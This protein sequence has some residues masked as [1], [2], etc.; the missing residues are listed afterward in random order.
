MSSKLVSIFY[1]KVVEPKVKLTPKLKIT[2]KMK[3]SNMNYIDVLTQ[4]RSKKKDFKDTNLYTNLL[5]K[6]NQ[7]QN[8]LRYKLFNK[9]S[10][11]QT[12]LITEPNR[13]NNQLSKY[14][15]ISNNFTVADSYTKTRSINSKY[16][17]T[18]KR[19]INKI[20]KFEEEKKQIK[21]IKLIKKREPMEL[22]NNYKD[23][24]KKMNDFNFSKFCGSH[25]DY[26]HNIRSKYFIDSVKENLKNEARKNKLYLLKEKEKIMDEIESRDKVFYPS[27][28]LQKISKKIKLILG[29]Q[30]KLNQFAEPI[31]FFDDFSNRINFLFDNYKPP[32]IKNNL[33][34]IT[35][36][37]LVNNDQKL[38]LMNRVGSSAI[39]YLSHAKIIL[40]KEKD[41]KAKFLFEKNKIKKKYNYYKK[42]SISNIYN[43][44]E[45]IEKLIYKDYYLKDENN[46]DYL[47]PE[48]ETLTFEEIIE[49][50]NYFENKKRKYNYI[51]FADERS[52]KFV[53]DCLNGSYN[54]KKKNKDT[55]E[56]V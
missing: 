44:K 31:T 6:K 24:V 9:N 10:R 34:K 32:H 49:Y 12:A 53:F 15:E 55:L 5:L 11:I 40:Q 46:Y 19:L 48:K 56:I 43:S 16:L 36:Y 18:P 4:I 50:K 30:T 25:T 23:F 42:L 22:T 21:K 20:I 26:A 37:D 54:Y 39:D 1:P 47:L 13:E 29:N 28:E 35:Y 27:L 17:T 38:N 14:K 51:F 7:K 41:A 45:E 52:K 2:E 3:L 33:T 8:Y